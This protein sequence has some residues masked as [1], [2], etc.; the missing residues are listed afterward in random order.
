MNVVVTYFP[1]AFALAALM[2]VCSKLKCEK[3]LH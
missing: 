3:T 2:N 1:R